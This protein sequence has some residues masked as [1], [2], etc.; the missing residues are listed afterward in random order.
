MAAGHLKIE[1]AFATLPLQG[2]S[3]SGDLSLIKRVG[4]GTLIAV[5]DGLGHGQQAASAA[6]AAVGAL[7]RYSREPLIDLVRRCHDALVGLRGVVLGL[8]YLDP[9]AATM[10]WLGVGNVGGVLL[11][12]D[13]GNRPS[14]I[15]LVP[16]AGFIGAEQPHPTTRSV[17][18]A[19]GDTVILHSDGI[20]DGFA[21]SLVLS[22]SPQ[23]I[24]DFVMTRHAKDNDDA[25]VLVARYA[26]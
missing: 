17:P 7:D 26:R 24:A 1:T 4:K 20:K 5:V 11:R 8:A 6:H 23:E 15:T 14:R 3:E 12:A 21:E 25:L 16:N 13:V 9:Q 2:Q 22:K 18:L 10:A 19:L